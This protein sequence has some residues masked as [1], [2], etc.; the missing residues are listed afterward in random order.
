[1]LVIM[2]NK[3]GVIQSQKKQTN[4]ENIYRINNPIIVRL[5]LLYKQLVILYNTL[6]TERSTKV[7]LM[8]I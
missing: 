7:Q 5:K 1:M 3:D 6:H 8:Y 2:I 4:R